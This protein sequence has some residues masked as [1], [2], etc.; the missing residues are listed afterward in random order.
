MVHIMDMRCKGTCSASN[1]CKTKITVTVKAPYS[2][3]TSLQQFGHYSALLLTRHN[4]IWLQNV[5]IK[6]QWP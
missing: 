2:D 5:T 3:H 1:S 4:N 6:K